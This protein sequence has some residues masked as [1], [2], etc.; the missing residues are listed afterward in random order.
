MTTQRKSRPRVRHRLNASTQRLARVTERSPYKVIAVGLYE[1]QVEYLDTLATTLQQAGWAQAN[2][3]SLLQIFV[4][5]ARKGEITLLGGSL[6][7][8]PA[9]A[10]SRTAAT[11]PSAVEQHVGARAN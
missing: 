9:A 11:A 6:R 4:N 5:S 3:S 1:D 10:P 7:L 2:R 8:P